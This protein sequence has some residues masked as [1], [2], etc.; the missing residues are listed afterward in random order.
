MKLYYIGM[1]AH[2]QN[3]AKYVVTHRARVMYALLQ[4]IFKLNSVLLKR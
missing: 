2:L 3:T 1:Y 4:W